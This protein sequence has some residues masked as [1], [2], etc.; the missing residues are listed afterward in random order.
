MSFSPEEREGLRQV[1]QKLLRSQ[2]WAARRDLLERYESHLRSDEAL[3]LL[4]VIRHSY[5]HDRRFQERIDLVR[6]LVDEARDDGHDGMPR[7]I[8][9]YFE[10]D[11]ADGAS[12]AEVVE[13]EPP[14]SVP[15]EASRQLWEVAGAFIRAG[16]WRERRHIVAAYPETFRSGDVEELLSQ[17]SDAQPD[18]RSFFDCLLEAIRTAQG[19]SVDTMFVGAPAWCFLTAPQERVPPLL[20]KSEATQLALL[21]FAHCPTWERRR[22]ILAT[23]E[24][25]LLSDLAFDLLEDAANHYPEGDVRRQ[26]FDT[27]HEVLAAARAYGIETA[28]AQRLQ[29]TGVPKPHPPITPGAGAAERAEHAI[30]LRSAVF[31]VDPALVPW[32]WGIF[33]LGLAEALIDF[34]VREARAFAAEEALERVQDALTIY[35]ESAAPKEWRR[36]RRVL[37][38]AYLYRQR[39]DRAANVEAAIATVEQVH[40]RALHAG[41]VEELAELETRL[42]EA[43]WL[44]LDGVPAINLEEAYA[45]ASRAVTLWQ[46]STYQRKSAMAEVVLGSVCAD[47]VVGD[48]GTNL[49]EAIKHLTAALEVLDPT[50][51]P[52]LCFAAQKA[53]GD[54]YRKRK[55]G[56][57]DD[58]LTHAIHHLEKGLELAEQMDAFWHRAVVQHTLGRAYF[59]LKPAEPSHR[60][61]AIELYKRALDALSTD[62]FPSDRRATLRDFGAV[63]FFEH[64][65]ED[66]LSRLDEAIALGDYLEASAYTRA[67]QF[68]ETSELP[69]V[70]ARRSYCLLRLD[71]PTEAL[72]GLQA[73]HARLLR[74]AL[75]DVGGA[76]AV[77]PELRQD[78]DAALRNLRES[79]WGTSSATTTTSTTEADARKRVAEAR[80]AIRNRLEQH[81]VPTNVDPHRLI[82]NGGAVIVPLVTSEGSAVFVLTA[83]DDVRSSVLS[84]GGVT[85]RDFRSI[86]DPIARANTRWIQ[87]QTALT[88]A[89][90]RGNEPTA[91]AEA[92]YEEATALWSDALDAGCRELWDLLLGPIDGRLR[93][94]AIQTGEKVVI[95]PSKWLPLLPLH[96]AWHPTPAGREY[97]LDNY[98]VSYAP[99]ADA[100]GVSR[101]RWEQRAPL[102][103]SLLSIVDPSFRYVGDETAVIQ[104]RFAGEVLTLDPNDA[105]LDRIAEELPGRTH[106]HFSCHGSFDVLDPLSSGLALPNGETLT[107]RDINSRLS[108]DSVRLVTLSACESG[109]ADVNRFPEQFV[110]LPAAFLQSGAAAVVGSLWSVDAESTTQLM[111]VLYERHIADRLQPAE[112]LREAQLAVKGKHDYSHPFY[113]GAF[114]AVGP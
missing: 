40:E 99:S 17:V 67:G 97:F 47:R 11:F 23:R 13:P 74:D 104:A 63:Y 65:W 8:T 92:E 4:A 45:Y 5:E 106:I 103:L 18:Y 27:A 90:D 24:E 72:A 43:Y 84:L 46:Q 3:G 71:R 32:L 31:Y 48:P 70:Y 109:V 87:A 86:I 77:M 28:Y 102:A 38:Y 94:R 15:D 62:I 44:R 41:S 100:L 6:M 42:A 58:N 29:P 108:L 30:Y 93:D 69:D 61:R 21:A 111:D 81:A 112:A 49:E 98:V 57:P 19:Q 105:T 26:P 39:G 9:Q 33:N 55:K 16:A 35:S 60:A 96:A 1:I 95:I 113:W 73:G 83:E 91:N 50:D 107:L 10:D 2:T 101:H 75:P 78:L 88:D 14:G 52:A 7:P 66:A 56:S 89:D 82:P 59:E 12:A 68:A 80:Q 20:T 64:R 22:E 110:G 34:P 36:A 54:V 114:V 76:D 53:L 85:D 37:G 79:A 51:R 25:L